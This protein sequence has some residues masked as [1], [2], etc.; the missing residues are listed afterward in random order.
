MPCKFIDVFKQFWQCFYHIPQE[1]DNDSYFVLLAVKE[2]EAKEKAAKVTIKSRRASSAASV[3]ISWS[4]VKK[5]ELISSTYCSPH[6]EQVIM[7]F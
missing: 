4:S 2:K 1:S 5:E 6:C 7:Q 3:S